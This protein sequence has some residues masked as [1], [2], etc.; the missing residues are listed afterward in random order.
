MSDQDWDTVVLKKT[1][2]QKTRGMSSAQAITG[3]ALHIMLLALY[4]TLERKLSNPL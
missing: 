1:H 4:L 3:K 2:A